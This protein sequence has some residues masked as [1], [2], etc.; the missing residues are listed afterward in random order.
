MFYRF[1]PVA[2]HNGWHILTLISVSIV[3]LQIGLSR[4]FVFYEEMCVRG[5]TLS[6]P[7]CLSL[8]RRHFRAHA[9]CVQSPV[10]RG[11]L[12]RLVGEEP[13]LQARV[14]GKLSVV[15]AI[16]WVHPYEENDVLFLLKVSRLRVY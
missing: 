13:V 11:R 12:A 7:D 15:Q 6:V 3:F 9:R 2:E 5:D 10:R 4:S 14:W 1:D 8:I 16:K